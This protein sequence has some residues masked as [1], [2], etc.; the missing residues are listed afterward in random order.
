MGE[1]DRENEREKE[2]TLVVIGGK[3]AESLGSFLLR[4]LILFAEK[5]CEN[6]TNWGQK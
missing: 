6:E 5:K 2:V 1:N 4:A 3:E